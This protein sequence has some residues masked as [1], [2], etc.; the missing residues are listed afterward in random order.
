MTFLKGT[1]LDE[2]I[3]LAFEEDVGQEDVTSGLL[4]D[5]N[6]CAKAEVVSK[7]EGILCGLF[8]LEKISAW[9]E[10]N[11]AQ[12]AIKS[13]FQD[14]SFIQ[15][16][17][18][19]VRIQGPLQTILKV[20]RVAL[21][22]LG[23]LSGIAT[24]THQFVKEVKGLSVD[25][26][27]T[28]K[29]TPGFRFLEKYAVK[30]GG[31]K[32]HRFGLYD[33]VLIKENHLIAT[34]GVKSAIETIH[35]KLK[36]KMTV[37]VEVKNL[38]EVKEAL[39]AK[40]D[41]ILLDNFSVSDVKE[42]LALIGKRALTEVSGGIHLQNVRRYAQTGVNRISIGA[43]THSAPNFDFSLLCSLPKDINLKK[44]PRPTTRPSN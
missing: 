41:I 19:V 32:N 38:K 7:S 39:E 13:E 1:H 18:V 22:F 37:E 24:L 30:I 23:R 31:G 3:R 8:L 42:A 21:N 33:G 40:A 9:P 36:K 29:T 27:D 34:Q 2:L 14:G 44:S 26:L 6:L 17:D 20:E 16:G 43:L 11:G 35:K 25:I 5:S 4:M 15:K 10:L 12:L 28:R